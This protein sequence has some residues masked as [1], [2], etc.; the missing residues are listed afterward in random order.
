LGS[1]P[2]RVELA[3]PTPLV[4]A[5]GAPPQPRR[6]AAQPWPE[7]RAI[8]RRMRHGHEPRRLEEI[9]SPVPV[10]AKCER[11][12]GQPA[13]LDQERFGRWMRHVVPRAAISPR[14]ATMI[15]K[16]L[17]AGRRRAASASNEGRH[18]ATAISLARSLLL[19]LDGN[20]ELELDLA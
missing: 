7:A 19:V 13:A 6:D 9:G 2:L 16:N 11:Q 14:P 20:R 17:G 8:A 15:Q 18:Q 5:T 12:S 10:T 3:T 4:A 1:E